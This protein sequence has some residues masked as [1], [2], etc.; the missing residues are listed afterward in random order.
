M[1]TLAN[2][3]IIAAERALTV[4]ASQA[5]LRFPRGVMIQRFRRGDLSALRHSGPHLMTFGACNLLM[6]YMTEAN[7]ERRRRFRRARIAA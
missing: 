7:S 6:L 5:T 1:A 4:M 2:T 3:E